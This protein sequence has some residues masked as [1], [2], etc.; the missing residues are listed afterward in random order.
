M[1]KY[2]IVGNHMS[3]LIFIPGRILL[4]NSPESGYGTLTSFYINVTS[5]DCVLS[6][7]VFY[8]INLNM[9]GFV[10]SD[11]ALKDHKGRKFYFD[12]YLE[13]CT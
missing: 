9:S 6:L 12:I 3:R 1:S 8:V 7:E 2:H 5:R 13:V 10:Y 11:F 4:F